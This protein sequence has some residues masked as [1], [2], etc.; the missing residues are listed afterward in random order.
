M[1]QKLGGV[2]VKRDAVR[3]KTNVLSCHLPP[4]QKGRRAR[5]LAVDPRWTHFSSL[6]VSSLEVQRI[7]R[8]CGITGIWPGQLMEDYVCVLIGRPTCQRGTGL[9]SG[10]R[11][12]QAVV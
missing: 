2:P 10:G 6:A 1:R 5:A 4:T 7:L 8:H 12:G 9:H 11:A 3:Y